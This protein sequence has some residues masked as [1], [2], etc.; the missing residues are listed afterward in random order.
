MRVMLIDD[1]STMRKI[2]KRVLVN[3][4][5]IEEIVEAGNGKEA[6]ELLKQYNNEFAFLLCDV[7]MPE[8]SGMETLR[9]IRGNPDTA[10]LP[11]IMCTSVA[12]KSQV[13]DAIKAGASNYVV[14]PFR[15]EDLEGKIQAVLNK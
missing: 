11:V 14:K 6:L 7:N 2:Q 1:S 15:P 13:L 8:M 10:K 4:P 9:A 3:I 5:G 12:E